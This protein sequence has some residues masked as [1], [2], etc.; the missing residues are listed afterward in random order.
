VR[1]IIPELPYEQPLAKGVWRYERDGRPTGAVEHWRLSTAHDG[2]QF[3]RVDLDARSAPSGRSYLFHAVLDPQLEPVRLQYRL[4]QG[5]IEVIGNVHLEK[6]GVLFTSGKD[7]GRIEEIIAMP[8]GYKFWF[9][10]SSALGLLALAQFTERTAAVGLIISENEV[11][12][13]ALL[14]LVTIVEKIGSNRYAQ[15]SSGQ[16]PIQLFWENQRRTVWLDAAGWPERM[17]RPDGL[18]AVESQLV[19]Y[20]HISKPG[21]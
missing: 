12:G 18:T 4:W 3:L 13:P 17:E 10:A 11:D 5:S 6:E 9:P 7:E 15:Q 20:Q 2:F 21:E 1:F 8:A 19:R 16:N 14:P